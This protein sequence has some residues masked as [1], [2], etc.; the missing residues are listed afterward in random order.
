MNIL[1]TGATGFIGTNLCAFLLNNKSVKKIIAIDNFLTSS[2][3]N[4]FFLKKLDKNKKIIFKNCDISNKVDI[5]IK[6]DFIVNLA[7]PASP[8]FYQKFPIETIKVSTYGV[9]NLLNLAKKNGSKFL[10]ASTSEIYGDPTVT[11]QGENYFGNVNPVGI[12]SCYDEGKRLAESI[13]FEYKKEF[14]L[15]VRIMRIFNTFGPHMSIDDGRVITNFIKQSKN[16]KK[17]TV[18][19]DGSQTRS[20]CFINDLMKYIEFLIFSKR[21]DLFGPFNIGNDT[22]I[23]INQLIGTLSKLLNKK[24]NVSYHKLPLDDPK[25]RMPNLQKIKKLIKFEYTP[26]EEA[27][28]KTYDYHK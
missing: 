17:I 5:R 7:C 2:K 4:F 1:V 8:P 15:D 14:K 26:L 9:F 10:Q 13:C 12:R 3:K 20:F 19:G 23:S 27:L 24:L 16:N 18:Y 21:K 28:K 6:I 11:P 22:E 25:R